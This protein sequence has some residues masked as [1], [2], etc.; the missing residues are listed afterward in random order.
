MII[1]ISGP[2]GSGKTTLGNKLKK[3]FGNKIVVEDIDDLRA[4][5]VESFYGGYN[6]I[7]SNKNFKW[8]KK[9]YQKWINDYVNKINKPLVF[10]GLNHMPWWGKNHYYDMHSKYNFY[11][12]IPL[13]IVFQQKC[14]RFFDD[15]LID[16]LSET[17]EDM[18]KNKKQ[19]IEN[20]QSGFDQECSYKESKKM[21]DIWDKSYKKQ[22][23]KFMTRENIFKKVS[24]LLFK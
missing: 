9:A 14:K 10:V 12:K 6:K 24:E 23:Y 8:N 1:H 11:I 15:V 19:T 3:K 22:G 7:W 18:K 5:F 20:L 13:D 21:Y 16:N 17:Y 4:R 2:S